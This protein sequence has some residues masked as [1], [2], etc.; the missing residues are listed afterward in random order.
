MPKGYAV[1]L[2]DVVDPDLY[3]EYAR[4]ATEIEA[5]HGGV[6]LAAADAAEVVDGEWPSERVVVLEFPSI[7]NARAWYA[8]PNYQD[9]IA[10]RHRATRSAVVFVEGFESSQG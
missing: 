10:L 3:L 4:Q 7:E 6:A 8:D 1:V 9:L 2:V 5:K